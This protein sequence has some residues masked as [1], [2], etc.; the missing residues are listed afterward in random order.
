MRSDLCFRDFTLTVEN[1][2]E[3]NESRAKEV[4]EPVRMPL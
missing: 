3:R 1:G 2:C 4:G